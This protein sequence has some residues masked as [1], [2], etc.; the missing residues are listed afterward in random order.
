VPTS[1]VAG[2]E[3]EIAAISA[4]P[5]R[6]FNALNGEWVLVSAD[7]TRRPWLGAEEAEPLE[8]RSPY[9]PDC[10]LCPGNSRISGAVNPAYENTFVFTNDFAALRPDSTSDRLDVGLFRAQGT[11]GTCRVVCFSPR[12]DL[13]LSGMATDEIRHIVDVWIGQTA[14]LGDLFTWV[15]V[16]ENRGEAMGASNPHPHCQ[17]WAGDAIPVEA[18]REDATQRSYL[19]DFGQQLLVAYARAESGGPRVIAESARWL[20]VVPFWAAWPFETLIVPTEPLPRLTML[21]DAHRDGLAA[22]IHDLAGRYDALFGHPFPYSMGWHQAPFHSGP[23]DHWQVHA[24]FYPP[25]LRSAVRKFMVGYEL[26]AEPQRDL[27]PEDAAG[28][29]R[30]AITAPAR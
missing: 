8:R 22:T 4:E 5:H 16:F 20:T 23:I 1:R 26:L 17:I 24:H 29:L 21:D 2:P 19:A 3:A 25:L 10:Y 18:A 9:D 30:A 6:R 7:R 14:E 12:H 13:T 28:R 11:R 27:T 15:Q